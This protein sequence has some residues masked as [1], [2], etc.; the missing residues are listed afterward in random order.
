MGSLFYPHGSL[1]IHVVSPSFLPQQIYTLTTIKASYLLEAIY[2]Y[3]YLTD[4]NKYESGVGQPE[5]V[6][7][8]SYYA[9]GSYQYPYDESIDL[10][11]QETMCVQLNLQW[12]AA[13]RA[14]I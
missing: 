2:L 13:C 14:T 11:I 6:Y 9:C 4:W 10:H 8:S 5:K 12:V 3:E 1:K 7:C